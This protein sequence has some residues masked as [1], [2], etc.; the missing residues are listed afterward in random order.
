MPC[1]SRRPA[2]AKRLIRE[3]KAAKKAYKKQLLHRQNRLRHSFRFANTQLGHQGYQ[4][5]DQSE[6]SDLSSL[7][8]TASDTS[9]QAYEGSNGH[10]SSMTSGD[11]DDQSMP[12]LPPIGS[13]SD[14]DLE[15]SSEAGSDRSLI[16]EVLDFD[17]DDE[18]DE[19]GDENNSPQLPLGK[20]DRLRRWV[21]DEIRMM[22]EKRYEIPRDG[23]PWG[24][25]YLHHVLM[26]LKTERA[27]HFRE[28]LRINPT[29]FDVR[30]TPYLSTTLKTHKCQWKNNLQLLF[31]DLGMTEMLQDYNQLQIGLELAKVLFPL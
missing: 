12:D 19:E 25:S 7:S 9:S 13:D 18:L 21:L 8:N 1:G 16:D 23:L 10:F 3:F 2:R 30:M 20:W 17:A 11:D 5:S 27:D 14:T 6:L 22:Y 15:F 28:A 29:T 26:R 4:G 31:I 24:P